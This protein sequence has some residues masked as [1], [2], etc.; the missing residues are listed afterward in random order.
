[1]AEA[2]IVSKALGKPVKVM[3]TREDDI[4]YDC[5][6]SAM[7]HRITGALDAQGRLTGWTTRRPAFPSRKA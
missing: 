6:R 4:K 5:F 2:V 3:W 7:S 1:M